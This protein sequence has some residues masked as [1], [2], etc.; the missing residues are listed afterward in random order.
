MIVNSIAKIMI[1]EH[2]DT[3]S[4]FVD[5]VTTPCGIACFQNRCKAG[6]RCQNV[7]ISHIAYPAYI[8]L[9]R[10]GNSFN[11]YC[12]PDGFSW[13]QVGS[14]LEVEMG[15]TVYVGLAVSSHNIKIPCIA[16][17]DNVSLICTE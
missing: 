16:K 1:R 10:E 9:N 5:L 2:L 12:S 14:R 4:S 13:K 17:F 11:A 6:E 7:D 3:Y 8:R 15:K